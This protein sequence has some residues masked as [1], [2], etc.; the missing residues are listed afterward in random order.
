MGDNSLT[1]NQCRNYQAID[2]RVSK[3][4]ADGGCFPPGQGWHFSTEREMIW[5]SQQALKYT[6][7]KC[8]A[9]GVL[10]ALYLKQNQTYFIV[11]KLWTLPTFVHRGQIT[12][13]E[14]RNKASK[15]LGTHRALPMRAEHA[16]VLLQ[17]STTPADSRAHWGSFFTVKVDYFCWCCFSYEAGKKA[18]FEVSSGR[19]R[20]PFPGLV[21]QLG[22]M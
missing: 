2:N 10:G 8:K 22:Q 6:A 12:S 1:C 21:S 14:S 17:S 4:A 3:T 15:Y 18:G 11:I 20:P 19:S 9:S 5:G 13:P 7:L 16:W